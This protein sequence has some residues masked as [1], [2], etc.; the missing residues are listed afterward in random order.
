MEYYLQEAGSMK[1]VY[2]I[3]EAGVNHNGRVETAL[4]LCDA[5]KRAGASAV[6]FQT[7]KT[8]KNITQWAEMAE[9]QKRHTAVRQSQFA[10]VKKLEL[11]HGAFRKIK[12]YCDKIGIEFLSTPDDDE[13]LDLLLKLGLETIKIGS[14]EVTNIP[15]LRKV[16]RS[17]KDIILST[18]M[19]EMNEVKSA[20]KIL[21][22]SG[23]RSVLLLHCTSEYPCP[24]A[25]V[26]LRAMDA[27]RKAFKTHVGYSDH[28]SGIAVAVAAVARGASIIEKHLTLDKRME[29]PD[30]A[31]SIDPSEFAE[32]VKA[33]RVVEEALGDG[34]KKVSPS[35]RK[36][37]IIVRRSI[38][39]SRHIKKG[40]VFTEDNLAAKRPGTGIS[41]VRWDG[42]I[43]RKA[44]RDFEEDEL[45]EISNNKK[46]FQKDR[47]G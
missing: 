13:S 38:V 39:A 12:K 41:P 29:G 18:G 3:A 7:F 43:G 28:T 19:S 31:A 40:D 25:D 16:G 6:K 4:K 42:V 35:E 9:Y 11:G 23:A 44:K 8:E 15:Y 30:H 22:A 21:I 14:G 1:G 37:L 20:Y 34:R 33:I 5:S 36:N 27:L 17:R 45:I 26:N 10:M 46:D 2:I 47:K 24:P 32:M